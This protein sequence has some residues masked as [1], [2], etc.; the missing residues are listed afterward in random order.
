MAIRWKCEYKLVLDIIP[1]V[2]FEVEGSADSNR[3]SI[4]SRRTRGDAKNHK[5]SKIN[6]NKVEKWSNGKPED[7]KVGRPTGTYFGEVDE[8]IVDVTEDCGEASDE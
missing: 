7:K 1:F 6:Y 5:K 8:V 2:R 3:H 4:V